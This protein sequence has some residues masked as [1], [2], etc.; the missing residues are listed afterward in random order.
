MEYKDLAIHFTDEFEEYKRYL[1]EHI[2]FNGEILNHVFFGECSNYFN[3]LIGK[4]KD[5]PKIKELFDYL[6]LMATSGDDEVKELLSVTI[7]AQL[8]DS[9]KLLKKAYKY[10]GSETR[11]ASNEIER[12]WGR[13]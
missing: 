10:M 3:E 1:Q 9:K 2:E 5:I 6:E 12:Y 8:G 7:L 11:K 13:N 4:E